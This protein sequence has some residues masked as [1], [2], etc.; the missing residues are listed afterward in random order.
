MHHLDFLD[1]LA[2]LLGIL[3]TV[4]KL[5][6]QGRNAS[7]FPHVK[8]EEFERWRVWTTSIY[9]LGSAVCFL[10]VIFHQGWAVLIGRQALTSPAAPVSFRYPALAMDLLFLIVVAATFIRA[11]RAR[12]LRRDLGIVLAGATRSG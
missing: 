7:D 6:T 11:S 12:A 10:R 2:I 1:I 9:R 8:P 4:A 3:F 5:D